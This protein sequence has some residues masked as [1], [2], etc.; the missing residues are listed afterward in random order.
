MRTILIAGG[1]GLIGKHLT[2]HLVGKGYRVHVLSR[3][4]L[5]PNPI[6]K[7]KVFYFVWDVPNGYIDEKAWDGVT[8][9]INLA[10][11]NIGSHRWT[12]SRKKIIINSRVH[13]TEL[14]YF[15]TKKLNLSLKSFITA[16]AVGYYGGKSTGK[17]Y[18]ETDAPAQDFQGNVCQKWETA[19]LLFE[20]IGIRTVQLRTG[21]VLDTNEGALP[22]MLQPIKWGLGAV[23][24]KGKQIIPW[25]HVEDIVGIYV[26]ALENKIS[27]AFNAVAPQIVDNK[28]FTEKLAQ[29]S[30]KGVKLP[31]VSSWILKL[32]LGQ[33]TELLLEGN[34]ISAEKITK[35]GYMFHYN[36]I[37]KALDNLI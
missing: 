7:G 17:T 23:L 24:G 34:A 36:T 37:E 15:H 22:K 19:S 6:E 29:I 11:S 33:R 25:I 12:A 28:S 27:G 9:I 2:K 13:S 10:G 1:T 32:I 18:I 20:Q 26:F 14:L 4:Y 16:S 21:V 5:K 30:G 35:A 8:D 3:R 31:N